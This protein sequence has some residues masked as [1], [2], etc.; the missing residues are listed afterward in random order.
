MPSKEELHKDGD[1]QRDED[2][3]EMGQAKPEIG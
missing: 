2:D 3:A 1:Q